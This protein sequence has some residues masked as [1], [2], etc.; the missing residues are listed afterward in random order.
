MWKAPICEPEIEMSIRRRA[1]SWIVSESIN[2][3]LW[4]EGD[5]RMSIKLEIGSRCEFIFGS[6]DGFAFGFGGR[7][8][9]MYRS[10]LVSQNIRCNCLA[11]RLFTF[12]PCV[13]LVDEI[14]TEI[15]IFP[16]CKFD[17][18]STFARFLFRCNQAFNVC[19]SNVTSQ[20]HHFILRPIRCSFLLL[21]V[22]Y[23]FLFIFFLLFFKFDPFMTLSCIHSSNEIKKALKPQ[24]H[25]HTRK[26]MKRMVLHGRPTHRFTDFLFYTLHMITIFQSDLC[27][28]IS[29]LLLLTTLSF[30]S[31]SALFDL[32]SSTKDDTK[33]KVVKCVIVMRRR[34]SHQS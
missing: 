9:T 24:T 10:L 26:Q 23:Y 2:W 27:S 11:F 28:F 12:R 25:T 13:H 15:D 6:V 7:W 33:W 8:M 17:C 19:G 32:I 1:T 31:S 14:H 21:F 5:H 16:W 18:S 30:S 29:R 20:A 4:H 22:S 34:S 3:L